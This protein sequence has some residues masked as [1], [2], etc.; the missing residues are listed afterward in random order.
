[1]STS[2]LLD[3]ST[4]L[5]GLGGDE[6]LFGRIAQIFARTAPDM[7]KLID[8]AVSDGDVKRVYVEAHSLKG[9]IG[10]FA[11]PE[12]FKCISDVC[13]HAKNG[14]LGAA[15]DAYALAQPLIKQLLGEVCSMASSV[16]PPPA[17]LQ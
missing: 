11:A 2:P 8:A 17:R 13:Q 15:R 9:S 4:T 12:V 5:C 3:V 6:A 7:L 1:M 16:S 14:D 10:V